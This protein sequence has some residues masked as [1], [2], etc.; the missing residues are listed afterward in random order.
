MFEIKIHITFVNET[1][2]NWFSGQI[3]QRYP[4]EN[5]RIFNDTIHITSDSEMQSLLLLIHI[6]KFIEEFDSS[7]S[8]MG[9]QIV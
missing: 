2:K 7:S 8:V 3:S 9:H 5:V 6:L 1:A 4:N